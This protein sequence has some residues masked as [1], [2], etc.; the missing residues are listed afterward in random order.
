[1][2]QNEMVARFTAVLPHPHLCA[3]PA[4]VKAGSQR[5]A[6]QLGYNQI[7]AVF[8]IIGILYAFET[9]HTHGKFGCGQSAYIR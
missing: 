6:Q 2:S 4:D 9:R 3:Q 5:P 8:Q 7:K 1:M